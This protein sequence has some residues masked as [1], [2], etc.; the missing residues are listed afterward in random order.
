MPVF[1]INTIPYLKNTEYIK[2]LI[3]QP[4]PTGALKDITKRIQAP[5]LSPFTINSNQC[6]QACIYAIQDLSNPT[7]FMCISQIPELYNFLIINGYTIDDTFTKIMLKNQINP[8]S[9]TN[10][11]SSLVFY[12]KS[13]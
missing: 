7:E 9:T 10:I 4:E 3:I 8:S 13:P 5:K 6:T 2:I 1:A 12:I 11:N